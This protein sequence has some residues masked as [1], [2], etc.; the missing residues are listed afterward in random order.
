VIRQGGSVDTFYTNDVPLLVLPVEPDSMGLRAIKDIYKHPFN[1]GY[2]KRFLPHLLLF[3]LAVTG[4]YFWLRQ[5]K[6]KRVVEEV[7]PIPPLPH[8][9]AYKALEELSAKKLWQRGEIKEHYT[10]LTAILREYLERRYD[11]HALEQTSDE[12]LAQLNKQNLSPLLLKDTE[13][14]LSV[15]DLIKFAKADPGMDLHAVTIER[16][17][18]FVNQTTPSFR[19]EQSENDLNNRGDETVE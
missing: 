5:R 12:I 9:W 2:Y 6:R 14:L 4:L 13:E 7:I 19:E 16:V 11:I 8:E 1:P 17:R 15:A 10:L 3:V 18:S